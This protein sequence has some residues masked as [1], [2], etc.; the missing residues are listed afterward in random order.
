[1]RIDSLADESLEDDERQ[2]PVDPRYRLLCLLVPSPRTEGS[3]TGRRNV[4][5]ARRWR[6]AIGS[7]REEQTP[8]GQNPRSATC[9]KMAG[10][11]RE[12]KAA[13]R[14]RKPASGTVVG[15]VGAVGGS[16]ATGELGRATGR[17]V[18]SFLLV[19]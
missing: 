18:D 19:R 11:R 10:R 17:D 3:A 16:R 4:R 14:L 8:G 6:R 9:L 2:R 15:S 5:K 13:E 1:M 7:A 12:E